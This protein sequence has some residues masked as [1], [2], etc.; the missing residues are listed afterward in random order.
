[1]MFKRL[2]DFF[3]IVNARAHT[4]TYATWTAAMLKQ[5]AFGK[6]SRAD[7]LALR[8]AAYALANDITVHVT[9]ADASVC[10]NCGE[11]CED[12]CAKCVA[13]EADHARAHGD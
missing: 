4:S 1:M 2:Y 13:A 10:S 9:L 5:D 11:A 12:M 8:E 6:M 3:A 7:L